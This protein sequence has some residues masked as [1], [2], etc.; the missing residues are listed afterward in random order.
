MSKKIK[1]N[2]ENIENIENP[3]KSK[4]PKKKLV[5]MDEEAE[6]NIAQPKPKSKSNTNPKPNPKINIKI[7]M[8]KI[9][10][11]LE[12]DNCKLENMYDPKK[13]CNKILLRKEELEGELLL[14]KEF[15]EKEGLA[16]TDN[17]FLYPNLND[18]NFNIK[19]AE[20]AEFADNKMDDEE[21]KDIEAR[22]EEL[23]NAPFEISPNQAFIRNF[24]SFQTPYNSMLLYG[25]LGSGK[26]CSAIGVAEEMRDYMKQMGI[27]KKIII[28]AS[29]N[30]QD[31]FRNAIFDERK[32]KLV[33]G[34]WNIRDCTGN[35]LLKEINPMNMKGITKEK[36]V[37]QIN[38]LIN[39][40]YVFLG[41]IEFANYIMKV[42]SGKPKGM[43]QPKR[44]KG[45]KVFYGEAKDD[46]TRTRQ[47]RLNLQN[48][49]N[50]R[51]IIIDEVHN[52][53]IS[54]DTTSKLVADNIMTLVESTQDMRLLLLSAT[55]MYNDYKEIIWLLNLMNKNDKRAT[56]EIKDVFDK[57]GEFQKNSVGEQSGKELLIRKATGYVSFVKG[58]NP[59]TFPFKVY[60]SIFS[61]ENSIKNHEYPLYQMNGKPILPDE[62][63]KFLDIYLIKIGSYQELCYR[64]IIDNLKNKK[65]T[66][67]T[68]TGV[69]KDMPNFENMDSFGYVLLA[70]PL[71]SLIMVYPIEGLESAIQNIEKSSTND[72]FSQ[73]LSSNTEK[74]NE[75]EDVLLVEEAESD[76]ESESE[77]E[78]ELEREKTILDEYLP[79]SAGEQSTGEQSAG[80]QQFTHTELDSDSD[81]E[82]SKTVNDSTPQKLELVRRAS[83]M[84]SMSSKG[85]GTKGGGT[86][87]GGK[88]SRE[89][90][91]SLENIYI[92]PNDLV[93]KKGLERTM[94]FIDSNKPP[95]KGAFEYKSSTLKN[96]GRIFSP[97]KIGDYSA[98]IKNICKNI[99]NSE[100]IAL[101][102]SQYIDAALI[103]MALALEEIGFTRFGDG[104]KSLF[105]TPPPGPKTKA[106]K[107][108]M[109][110]G[111]PRL[112][113]N[114]EFEVKSMTNE[115][116]KNGERIKVVLISQAGT[117]GIDF[118]YLR[119][120]HILE[121]WYN[122]SRIEQIIGRAVRN[123]G[124]KS[125]P[126][127]KRNVEI[128]LYGTLLDDDTQE[129]ADLY[130]YRV[131]E[132]KAIQIGKVSRVLKENAVDCILNDSQKKLTQKMLNVDVRQEL[133]NGEIIQKFKVGDI[134]Y[135]S[136][137]D[138]ME[139]M[140]CN[141][142]Y[143]DFD[144]PNDFTYNEAFIAMNSEKIIKKIRLLMKERYFYL[145]E[146]LIK[147][148]SI[149]HPY[150]R[151]QIFA[152]L[153]Q[154]VEDTS[155]FIV[156]RYGRTGYLV[157]I[158]EYYLF[159][160]SELNNKHI[161]I[162]D[163]SVPI[164]YKPDSINFDIKRDIMREVIAA[165]NIDEIGELEPQTNLGDVDEEGAKSIILPVGSKVLEKMKSNFNI[166]L[167][168]SS[169][170]QKI[171]RGEENI[172][173]YCGIAMKKLIKDLHLPNKTV[174]ELLIEHLVDM[175]DN[176]E[177]LDLLNYIYLKDFEPNSF[178]DMIQ[179]Y[180]ERK[181]IKTRRFNAFVLFE[182]DKNKSVIWNESKKKW[183]KAQPEDE[184]E[185]NKY[186][187][188]NF[189][190]KTSDYSNLVGF[191]GK[192]Q[193][194]SYLVFKIKDTQAKRNTGARCD[195]S[196]KAKKIQIINAI[197]GEEKYDKDNSKTIGQAEFCTIIEFILRNNNNQKK[198]GKIWFLNIE[199]A[200][201]NK[202][203]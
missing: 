54:G 56:I 72:S 90:S 13:N 138:Y 97:D 12:N 191:I 118:K 184:R 195:E 196:G 91:S 82:I 75:S 84:S 53:R 34:L 59:Y 29:P 69:V 32:L 8:D 167:E 81:S 40:Y 113:P 176:K 117:E 158:G 86:K 74:H 174:L 154:L 102:Y 134:P 61:P 26:T 181:I 20:K 71:E 18:P 135:S 126:F 23:A 58:E 199:L 164:D 201:L 178:E 175:L 55:P 38:A 68:K 83:S 67:T 165:P 170:T 122:M 136:A 14:K 162:F 17:Q 140:E 95:F 121:P 79:E 28:V 103:P 88:S 4:K 180:L 133:S 1:P 193:K 94:N 5:I 172:Y 77:S 108:C 131:A 152:A 151:V 9:K 200:Y 160:P 70:M 62:Q 92:S 142:E 63:L 153:T 85:G 171:P 187:V 194:N 177:T 106:F 143:E 128:F 99:I 155:E 39:T 57:D 105:K 66:I 51:L 144:K 123:F 130:V 183:T 186:L 107:Y 50:G 185:I 27:S 124:H 36:I 114:N 43:K 42:E 73:E 10:N 156:D 125:L 157:N 64:F 146:D 166:A 163:R 98:K 44:V 111:D 24:L 189:T 203:L 78:S 19:I 169:Q 89:T 159:Q 188:D 116:N 87:G 25:G 11:E 7:E 48:E 173:K 52:I 80:E 129:A 101:I 100:G 202:F 132:Y 22:A 33:D 49:F 190:F 93:G 60:P 149:P 6:I 161:S 15:L 150:P 3:N 104:T 182:K 141:S 179:K 198:D 197:L 45:E 21:Y 115:D 139:C 148:I 47:Q 35:K 46:L 31:N 65:I 120:V 37:Y 41:Y 147:R 192:D 2:V 112:S 127:I 76:S 137:C 168:A 145:K 109:I 16:E 30:V 119:Q 110:T 96:Y